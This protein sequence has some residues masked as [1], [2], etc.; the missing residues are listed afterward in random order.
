MRFWPNPC[1]HSNYV[2][3][4]MVKDREYEAKIDVYLHLNSQNRE[5]VCIR[6]GAKPPDYQS[7]LLN[8]LAKPELN[9]YEPFK[10]VYSLLREK[11]IPQL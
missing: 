4:L 10:S 1:E 11:G 5:A 7:I 3:S 6:E 9:K 2:G 8:W